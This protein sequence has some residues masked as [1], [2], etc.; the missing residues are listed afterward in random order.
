MESHSNGA[1]SE[2]QQPIQEAESPADELPSG[3][4]ALDQQPSNVVEDILN[5]DKEP[6]KRHQ[7]ATSSTDDGS[8]D[9]TQFFQCNIC[10]D[11]VRQPVV[12]LCGHLFWYVNSSFLCH[13]EDLEDV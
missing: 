7:Q 3:N 12:T 1:D 10:F 13:L 8:S 4:D 2:A 5:N 9:D 6:S 11:P